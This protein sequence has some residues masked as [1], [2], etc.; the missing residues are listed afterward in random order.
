MTE[1]TRNTCDR[2]RTHVRDAL[3]G[4][5]TA[6][7]ALL[8]IPNYGNVGDLLIWE[9]ELAFLRA[10]ATM[11]T[12]SSPSAFFDPTRVKEHHVILLQG[13]GN[14]GDLYP[15][16]RRF[17]EHIVARFTKNR[18]ILFPQT[19]FFSNDAEIER[20]AAVFARHPDLTLCAREKASYD[21]LAS[22]FSGNQILLV[23]DMAFFAPVSRA[24]QAAGPAGRALFLSRGD[25]E[26]KEPVDAGFLRN[27]DIADWPS[28]CLSPAAKLRRELA[29]GGERA[30]SIIAR[31]LNRY[32]GT[33]LDPT[34]RLFRTREEFIEEGVRLLSGYDLIITNRLHGHILALLLGLP[35]IL[36]DNTYGKNR[37]FHETWLAQTEGSFLAADGSAL[38][39]ILEERFPRFLRSN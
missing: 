17:K 36:L 7:C 3:A 25:R 1:S 16:T 34:Y 24:P 5:I 12:Y 18:I 31:T 2:L 6:D 39:A 8:D 21:L 26:R 4:L 11:P 33:T 27:I 30:V 28:L 13:G 22:R 37:N 9:G 15:K 23:P 32:F 14:F 20:T 29:Q 35:S 19:A 38:R 10:A